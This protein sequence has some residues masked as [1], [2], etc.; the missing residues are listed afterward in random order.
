MKVRARIASLLLTAV[1]FVPA[2][3]SSADWNEGVNGDISG[4]RL[5]PSSLSLAPGENT[6]AGT[7]NAGDLDYLRIDVPGGYFL[8]HLNLV[9]FVSNDSLAFI[10]IQN[11]T[12]FTQPPTGTD[13]SQL[14]GWAH[15]GPAFP[16]DYLPILG[17]SEGAIGFTGPLTA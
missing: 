15:F 8:T 16:V 5:A 14:L 6:I 12:T 13:V 9:N 7:T 17:G 2:V 4:N 10:A 3:A 1:L 11:G